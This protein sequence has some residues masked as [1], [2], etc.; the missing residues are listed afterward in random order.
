MDARAAI[1]EMDRIYA[2]ILK[3][4]AGDTRFIAKLNAAQ[5]AWQR[6]R[7]AHLESL[8]PADDKMLAYG[9]A[10][11][12]CRKIA[13]AALTRERINHLRLWLQGVEEGEVCAGSLPRRSP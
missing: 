4:F 10:Y 12:H 13:S 5:N 6:Y 3:R 2:E 8:Y 1:T 7:E 9:S 11:R